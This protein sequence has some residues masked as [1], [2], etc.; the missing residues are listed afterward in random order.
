MLV[1]LDG[2]YLALE[3]ARVPVLDRGFLFGDGVYEVIPAYGGH[4]FRLR[5]HLQRLDRSLAAIRMEPPLDHRQWE[6]I[7]RRLLAQGG[8]TDQQL[9][10]QVTRGS[11]DKR[12][13]AIPKEVHPTLFVM[14]GPLTPRDPGLVE[15]GMSAIT[16]EDIRWQR[17]DIKAITLLAN[18][19]AQQEARDAG[20]QEA[21][22]V[23]DGLATEG[24]ASNFFL[25]KEGLILTP[26][27]ST[28]LLPG[29]TRDLVLELARE[30]GLPCREREIP[31]E[32]LADADELWVTSSTKEVMPVTRLDGRPVGKGA[33]G[34]MWREMDAL[35]RACKIRLRQRAMDSCHD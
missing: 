30:A 24:T 22:L 3:Q 20:A 31:V 1:Y 26:P 28:H 21:I 2:Q 14:A 15:Q 27:K 8:D 13:H 29:I 6:E 11:Y 9:Y 35:Y 18:I 16:L 7:F 10:L 4:P 34:P 12:L 23:R 25:V 17:C 32:E 33:P 19:L 5:E